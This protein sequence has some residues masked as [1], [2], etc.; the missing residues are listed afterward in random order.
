MDN[1]YQ[2][3]FEKILNKLSLSQLSNALYICVNYCLCRVLLTRAILTFFRGDSEGGLAKDQTCICSAYKIPVLCTCPPG[4]LSA[5]LFSIQYMFSQV[6]S[7]GLNFFQYYTC[8]PW[9]LLD[10]V[11]LI[12]RFTLLRAVWSHCIKSPGVATFLPELVLPLK[13]DI[14]YYIIIFIIYFVLFNTKLF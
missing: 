3:R 14:D 5:A 10:I 2:L 7:R 11:Y 12:F 1:S 9:C 8:S 6:F 4:S 13:R